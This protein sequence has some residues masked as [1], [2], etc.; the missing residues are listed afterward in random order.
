MPKKRKDLDDYLP[1]RPAKEPL[2][3]VQVKIP[4]SMKEALAKRLAAKGITMR[5]LVIAQF[6]KFLDDTT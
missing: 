5:D 2:T 4:V 3:P 6:R 1:Y